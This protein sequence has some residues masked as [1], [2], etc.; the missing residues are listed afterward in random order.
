MSEIAKPLGG[1]VTVLPDP[2]EDKTSGGIVIPE[3]AKKEPITGT[4]IA[5]GEGR[6]NLNGELEPMSVKVGDRVIFE[7]YAGQKEKLKNDSGE[8]IEHYILSEGDILLVK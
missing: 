3:P 4:V 1:K 5:V 6:T 8:L 2:K 7:K